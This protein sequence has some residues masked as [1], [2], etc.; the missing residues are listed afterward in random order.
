MKYIRPQFVFVPSHYSFINQNNHSRHQIK[1][2]L[3][4]TLFLSFCLHACK[5]ND[6]VDVARKSFEQVHSGINVWV[7]LYYLVVKLFPIQIPLLLTFWN[8][9][10][11][12][13]N[14]FSSTEPFA[15]Q[16]IIGL[17]YWQDDGIRPGLYRI[18]HTILVIARDCISQFKKP[19][20]CL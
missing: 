17:W 18:N 11:D 19:A 10:P 12:R 7:V 2:I 1:T 14:L 16:L 13:L 20:T 8:K 3:R 5:S 9:L 4:Q 6:C 15:S